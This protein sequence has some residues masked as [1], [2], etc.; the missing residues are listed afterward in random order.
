MLYSGNYKS[1]RILQRLIDDV[2]SLRFASNEYEFHCLD[3]EDIAS[4]IVHNYFVTLF[5][6]SNH[7]TLYLKN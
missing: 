5:L 4:I 1:I 6:I 7:I 3:N 2:P